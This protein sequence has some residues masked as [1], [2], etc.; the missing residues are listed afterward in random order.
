MTADLPLPITEA[1]GERL[2]DAAT[3]LRLSSQVEP[4]DIWDAAVEL[5]EAATFAVIT[6]VGELEAEVHRL[7]G[8]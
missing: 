1:L 2:R 8:E 5:M 7:R 6:A 4:R 3:F